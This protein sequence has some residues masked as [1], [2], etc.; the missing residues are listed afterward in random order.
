MNS[1]RVKLA[2]CLWLFWPVAGWGHALSPTYYP[3]GPLPILLTAEWWPFAFLIPVTIAVEALILW[4]WI[5]R[6]GLLQS[7]WR[8]AVLYVVARAAET[9]LLFALQSIPLFHN[10]GWG[11][12]TRDF[13]PLVLFLAG[14]LL[15]V[16]PVGLLLYRRQQVR[17]AFVVIAVC[18]ASLAGDLSAA[19]CSVI[20]R[21]ARYV[22]IHS[23]IHE[24]AAALFLPVLLV[25]VLLAW[26]ACR[27]FK[28]KPIR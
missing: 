22:L 19:G 24:Y 20:L 16:I 10:A 2:I 25:A 5:R 23:E 12:S 9:A 11:P 14:G 8:A 28:R 6:L 21:K 27:H 18:S 4:A 17:R 13:V 7:L 1:A 26:L 15:L 3:L